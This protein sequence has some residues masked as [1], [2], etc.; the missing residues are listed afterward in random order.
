MDASGNPMECQRVGPGC[1]VQRSLYGYYPSLPANA[2]F[3]AFFAICTIAN[4]FTGTWKRTWTY[5]IAMFFGCLAQ[6]IGYAGRIIMNDNPFDISGF[7]IQICC[8]TLAP[9][10]NS[11]AIYLTLKHITLCFGPEASRVP[12]KWYT[13]AFIMTDILA[14]VFQGAGGGIAASADSD[15]LRDIG[16]ALMMTGI[17]L[18]VATLVVFGLLVV[19]YVVRRRK[20]STPLSAEAASTKSSLNFR[21]FAAALFI[22][23][24]AILIRCVYRIAEMAGGWRNPIMQD[25]SLFIGL[26]ST[27]VALATLLQTAFHPGIFFSRLSVRWQQAIGEGC[28]SLVPSE[29]YEGYSSNDDKAV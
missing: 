2:F 12:P 8:L 10:F 1:P 18:Q 6:V 13:W 3:L 26:D 16:D 11:A 4:A 17:C 24:L 27:M 5:L 15:S 23:Y 14:L 22:A 9:A 29:K 19:D 28:N 21:L 25:E 7:Q 20:D